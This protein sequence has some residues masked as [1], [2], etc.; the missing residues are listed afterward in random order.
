MPS[1]EHEVLIDL[2]RRQPA[3]PVEVL[4]ALT[5]LDVPEYDSATLESPD[6]T[7][8]THKERRADSVV[9]VRDPDGRPLL[10][11]VDEV[12]RSIDDT[13]VYV[14]PEYVV[15]LRSRLAC[16]VVLMVVCAS[17]V[18]AEWART[19]IVLGGRSQ[20]IPVVIGPAQVPIISPDTDPPVAVLSLLTHEIT[21]ETL[22]RLV[23]A[24]GEYTAEIGDYTDLVLSILSDDDG[25]YLEE[26]VTVTSGERYTSDFA[27]RYYNQGIAEGLVE[28]IHDLLADRGI[29]LTAA[30]RDRID[31]CTD[32]AVLRRWL[33]RAAAAQSPGDV[34]DKA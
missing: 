16:P 8:V 3:F 34:F 31:S 11:V 24:F 14:W 1:D 27:R 22:A 28:G 12:Q 25:D 21:K 15:S 33:V 9:T 2:V 20:V 26:L 18:V 30:E 23:Q 10:G 17:D 6:L 13:K 4:S 5:D 32:T 29:E 7:E 19:P